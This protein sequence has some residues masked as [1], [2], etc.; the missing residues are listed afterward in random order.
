LVKDGL[1]ILGG[2]S[3]ARIRVRRNNDRGVRSAVVDQYTRFRFGLPGHCIEVGNRETDEDRTD[4]QDWQDSA[5]G[6]PIDEH[7]AARCCA[8]HVETPVDL[9]VRCWDR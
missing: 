2:M 8:L 3:Q 6:S 1:Q 4:R 7:L 5:V 9:S